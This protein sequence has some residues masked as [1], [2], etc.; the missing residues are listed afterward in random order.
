MEAK[1]RRGRILR[2]IFKQ[3]R[4]APMPVEF[5]VAWM[6]AYNKGL[7]DGTEAAAIPDSLRHIAERAKQSSLTLGS[8][9]EA[10]QQTVRLWLQ[11]DAPP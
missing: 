6:I 9:R 5:H 1:I 11:E 2:E 3:E 8:A 10:W 4:L 7:L